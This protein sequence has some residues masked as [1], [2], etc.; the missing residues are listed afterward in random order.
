MNASTI[1]CG[2]LVG[3]VVV[4]SGALMAAQTPSV[5]VSGGAQPVTLNA[6]ELAAMP[7]TSVTASVC[8]PETS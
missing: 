2:W 1:R 4:V 8:L 6:A 3:V 5:T 7:R